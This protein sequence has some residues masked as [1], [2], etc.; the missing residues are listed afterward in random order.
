ME[1]AEAL[2]SI[3]SESVLANVDLLCPSPAHFYECGGRGHK[4]VYSSWIAVDDTPISLLHRQLKARAKSVVH[5]IDACLA[6]E[7]HS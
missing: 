1:C 5:E 7:K 6:H 3:G 2:N 4:F